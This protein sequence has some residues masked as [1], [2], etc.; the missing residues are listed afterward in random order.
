MALL[1]AVVREAGRTRFGE[2]SIRTRLEL[3][4]SQLPLLGG[5]RVRPRQTELRLVLFQPAVL[6]GLR[7]SL[8]LV[9]KDVGGRR[10]RRGMEEM[11]GMEMTLRS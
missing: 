5:P 10:A 11:S 8:A 6:R 2:Q 1:T 4:E 9:R 3:M 7:P